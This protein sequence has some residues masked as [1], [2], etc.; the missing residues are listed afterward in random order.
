M[1]K[2]A[3][4]TA[5]HFQPGNCMHCD[6]PTCV[7]ACPTG[8]TYKDEKD[9]TVKVNEKLCIGCGSCI[10]ACPYG[11]RYRHPQKKIVDKCDFCEHRRDRGELP[12]CVVTCPTKARVFGNIK[13]PDSDAARLLKQNKTTQV[14]NPASNTEP[15]I[16][17][18]NATAPLDWP[19]KAEIPTPIQL[20]A[21]VAKPLIWA[22]VG[23]NALGVLAML[24]K[25]FIFPDD[26][27]PEKNQREDSNED[28]NA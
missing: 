25:Q 2:T 8:A 17:Y 28:Q 18:L 3:R 20:W 24:G 26:D 11:A 4:N 12:A 15:N 1:K 23:I 27:Q 7:Q 14:I 6:I 21:K 22:L 16:Y 13:D 10:P 19:V 9:G 5:E